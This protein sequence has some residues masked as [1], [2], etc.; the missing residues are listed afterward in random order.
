MD[1][2]F[3]LIVIGGGP[4]GYVAAIKAAKLGLSTALVEADRLGG[5]CLNRGCIPTKA[6]LHAAGIYAQA[7]AGERFGIVCEDVSVDDAKFLAYR[8]ETVAQL[9]TGVEGLLAANGVTVISG[10]ATVLADKS[11]Y[12]ETAEGAT[13]YSATGVL[14]AVGAKPTQLPLPGM[15][16]PQVLTSDALFAREKLPTS[17]VIV[18]GGVIGVEFA[19]ALAELG[20][21]V[22]I[23]EGAGQLLPSMDKEISQ[24]L[25]MALKKRG[26]EIYTSAS[27]EGFVADGDEV[28]TQFQHKDQPQTV[29]SEVVLCAVGRSPNTADLFA[30]GAAPAMERGYILVNDAHETSIPGLYAIGDCTP[31]IQ[32]AHNASAQGL[33]VAERLAGRTPTVDLSVVPSCIYTQPEIAATGLTEAQAKAAG[34]E[35]L[36]GKFVMSANGKTLIAGDG[37]GFVKIIADGESHMILGAQLMCGRATDMIGELVTAVACGLT[38]EQ[39]L[40]GMRAHPT[41]NEGIGEALEDLLGEAIHALPQRKKSRPRGKA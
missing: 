14:I 22:T 27:V 7:A 34:R 37:R 21:R 10:R 18:G 26:V 32:L 31:G 39:L 35:V 1:K 17:I 19:T 11:V 6:L 29:T 20:A 33:A 16:L 41:Y 24:N 12:V 23:L 28:T 38:A 2:D 30:D 3:D 9:V 8:Q 15:D 40:C 4:G 5:T 36:V 13:T 25:K